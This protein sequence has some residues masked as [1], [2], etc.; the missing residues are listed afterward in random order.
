MLRAITCFC[1]ML[2]CYDD[3]CDSWYC[4]YRITGCT[5]TLTEIRKG[6]VEI[7]VGF[8]TRF[9]IRV[10]KNNTKQTHNGGC[11][12]QPQ[13]T[14]EYL[15]VSNGVNKTFPM[16]HHWRPM[17]RS[18]QLGHVEPHNNQKGH[19]GIRPRTRG[20]MKRSTVAGTAR[21]SRRSAKVEYSKQRIGVI[22]NK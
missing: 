14:R 16:A 5:I 19:L 7:K 6:I 8:C 13:S 2:I 11:T 4:F 10:W 12:R 1:L 9:M 21:R 20:G 15:R 22:M 18:G 3:L 17:L